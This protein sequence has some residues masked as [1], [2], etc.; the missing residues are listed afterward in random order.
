MGIYYIPNRNDINTLD[1]N[2]AGAD[3]LG[4]LGKY[5]GFY[6]N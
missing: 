2:Y 3:V 5:S 1:V 6:H 4:L